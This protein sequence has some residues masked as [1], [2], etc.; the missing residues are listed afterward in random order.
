MSGA[1]GT[2]SSGTGWALRTGVIRAEPLHVP[3]G[4][5][6]LV[7][8]LRGSV[9]VRWPPERRAKVVETKRDGAPMV[10][11]AGF[12]LAVA[13]DAT[14]VIEPIAESSNVLVV[15]TSVPREPARVRRWSSLGT[16]SAA[17]LPVALHRNEGVR[18]EL[19][20]RG[21]WT[22]RL[23]ER[24]SAPPQSTEVVIGGSL[25]SAEA[26]WVPGSVLPPTL[27][28]IGG[29]ATVLRILSDRERQQ[30]AGVNVF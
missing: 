1:L 23:A 4:Q 30:A 25:R 20:R 14:W 24:I 8:V 22:G 11:A 2:L 26:E 29:R 28:V 13:N 17:F 10:V 9:R 5:G 21:G 16:R 19:L 3:P 7:F 6:A 18:I 27:Q 15:A 12:W